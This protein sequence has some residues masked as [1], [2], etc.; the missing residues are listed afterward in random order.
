MNIINQEWQN[1]NMLEGGWGFPGGRQCKTERRARPRL[2][3]DPYLSAVRLHQPF[4]DRQAPPQTFCLVFRVAANLVK[5]LKDLELYPQQVGERRTQDGAAITQRKGG[6]ARRVGWK[7]LV[8][9]LS[10]PEPSLRWIVDQLCVGSQLPPVR[11]M[12]SGCRVIGAVYPPNGGRAAIPPQQMS[13][14]AFYT[15][16]RLC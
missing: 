2:L 15:T 16:M 4:D 1:V 12:D 8:R 7:S 6:A 14:P 10:S 11:L 13:A 5:R 3:G 9:T